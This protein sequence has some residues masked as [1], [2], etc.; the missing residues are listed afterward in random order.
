M[1]VEVSALDS[2]R[3]R[4]E[5]ILPAERVRSIEQT[6]YAELQKT[7]RVKG[8]RRGKVPPRIIDLYFKDYI[9]TELKKRIVEDSLDEALRR[10]DVEPL[11]E[12]TVEF[13]NDDVSRYSI[14]CEVVPVVEVSGYKGVEI[15]AGSVLVTEQDVEVELEK[16]RQMHSELV[17]KEEG[18]VEEGDFVVVKY[19][20]YADGLPLEEV[21]SE[22]YPL[23][24]GSRTLQPEFEN[25]LLGMRKGE[26][27]EIDIDFPADYPDRN[28]A[29]KRITFRMSVKEVKQK[30]PPLLNEDFAKDL[31]FDSLEALKESVRVKLEK[32]R[33]RERRTYVA[34]KIM[35]MLIERNDIPLPQG[36]LAWRVERS[37]QRA[38]ANLDREAHTTEEKKILEGPLR[39][40]LERE[41]ERR[42]KE[43]IL[44]VNI[45]R[46]EKIVVSDEE[47][48]ERL[49]RIAV[50]MRKPY[51]EVK[52]LYSKSGL[53]LSLKGEI[54]EEKVLNF[55]VDNAII[56]ERAP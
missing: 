2:T 48:E 16:L 9:K 40:K 31:G 26:E 4:V 20:G 30:K 6:I 14:L 47:V 33:E 54:L 15:E 45:S 52:A 50:E 29:S 56:K 43:E 10:A 28:Y 23:E 25:A 55:L 13:P 38:K 46:R 24:V 49:R 1:H 34:D 51:E 44:V 17:P 53:V 36:Y 5:V 42:I 11:L 35:E 7:A 3:R 39:E 19:Q 32:E 21:R 37:L 12:P 18:V 27:K 41:L 8:F 22:G